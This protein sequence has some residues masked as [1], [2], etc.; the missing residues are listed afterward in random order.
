MQITDDIDKLA[1]PSFHAFD[2]DDDEDKLEKFDL[3]FN[4]LRKLCDSD[5]DDQFRQF[6]MEDWCLLYIYLCS[7]AQAKAN[8]KNLRE[9][10]R[11]FH[12]GL[13]EMWREG[14]CQTL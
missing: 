6:I 4:E 2:W 14:G 5:P 1:I 9:R 3:C 12:E 11:L 8:I 13:D 7:P 10:V